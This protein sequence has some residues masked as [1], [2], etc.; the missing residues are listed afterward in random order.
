MNVECSQAINAPRKPG[1]KL[2]I[3]YKMV[4]GEHHNINCC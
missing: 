1:K 4:Y 3:L 2:V